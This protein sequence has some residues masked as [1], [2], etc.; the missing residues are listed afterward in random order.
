[1]SPSA[2]SVCIAI[3]A[4]LAVGSDCSPVDEASG[5]RNRASALPVSGRGLVES[6]ETC[7]NSKSWSSTSEDT[8]PVWKADGKC[9]WFCKQGWR[10]E[11]CAYGKPACCQETKDSGSPYDKCVNEKCV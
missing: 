2:I 10:W 8:P 1:M 9:S 3:A 5:L 6:V 7:L 4:A 11:S